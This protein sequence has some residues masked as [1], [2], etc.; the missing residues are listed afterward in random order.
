M[1]DSMYCCEFEVE[2]KDV[3][4]FYIY[5]NILKHH[6]VGNDKVSLLRTVKTSRANNLIKN[7][8]S[9]SHYINEKKK[10]EQIKEYRN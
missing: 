4:T 5:N 8:F 1:E 6:H 9:I 2:I 3:P 7:S 10:E